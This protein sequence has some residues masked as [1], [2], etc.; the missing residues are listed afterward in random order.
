M[1][2]SGGVVGVKEGCGEVCIVR[3]RGGRV[4]VEAKGRGRGGGN[5]NTVLTCSLTLLA[6]SQS[7]CLHT[8]H[9]PY[10]CVCVCVCVELLSYRGQ[11]SAQPCGNS[12]S[13]CCSPLGGVQI[14]HSGVCDPPS[15]ITP[16]NQPGPDQ[17]QQTQLHLCV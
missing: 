14:F 7:T 3:W 13:A 16:D 5:N 12:L 17:P 6:S 1:G 9:R 11:Y 4:G 8:A 10:R 2:K 15:H